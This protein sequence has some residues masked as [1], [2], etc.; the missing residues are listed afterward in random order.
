MVIFIVLM[1]N[2]LT[3][4]LI[5]IMVGFF[6]YVNGDGS[7]SIVP[8]IEIMVYLAISI[9]LTSLSFRQLTFWT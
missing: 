4:C 6:N 5:V 3:F 9:V 7:I 2:G 1:F 8:I